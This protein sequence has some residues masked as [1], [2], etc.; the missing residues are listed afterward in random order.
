MH[1]AF[2][3]TLARDRAIDSDELA[4]IAQ[5]AQRDEVVDDDER[6]MVG[7]ILSRISR[8]MVA[9]EV[10]LDLERFKHRCGI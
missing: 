9:P 4:V 7:R 6:K 10:W 8:R 1:Y 2:L 5:L 3:H